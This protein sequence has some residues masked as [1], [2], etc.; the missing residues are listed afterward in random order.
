MAL[1]FSHETNSLVT[2]SMHRNKDQ[3]SQKL[4]IKRRGGNR[5]GEPIGILGDAGGS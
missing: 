1:I 3:A 4:G 5:E 2:G